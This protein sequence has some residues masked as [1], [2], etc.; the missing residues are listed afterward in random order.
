[1]RYSRNLVW[2]ERAPNLALFRL[3]PLREGNLTV[4]P[5]EENWPI[6]S[7]GFWSLMPG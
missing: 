5:N 4:R 1:M 2:T 3:G 7:G 6:P